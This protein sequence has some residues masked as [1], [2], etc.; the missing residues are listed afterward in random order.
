MN[1]KRSR[2]R[3]APRLDLLDTLM[4]SYVDWR[5]KSRAVDESYRAW[6]VSTG[7]ERAAAFDEYLAALG[8]EEHAACGY[9]HV[10]EHTQAT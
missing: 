2:R 3:P 5:D 7:G 9:K 10:V 1:L 4:D 6:T 8:Q